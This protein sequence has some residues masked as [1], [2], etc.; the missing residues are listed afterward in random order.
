[1]SP[2]GQSAPTLSPAAGRPG[3]SLVDL[4]AIVGLVAVLAYL[5][6]RGRH[7]WYW[8]DEALS[9][10]MSSHP[11]AQLP[12][13]LAQDTSPPLYHVLLNLWVTWFGSSEAATHSLSTLFALAVVPA[14]LW[15][16]WSLF[17]RRTGWMCALLAAVSPFL[18]A[19]ANETR[20]YSLVALLS[21]LVTATFLHAFV[22][23]RRCFVPAFALLLA[24]TMYTHYWGF[25]LALGTGVALVVVVVGGVTGSA[26]RR[27][28]V[29][30]AVLAYGAAALLFAP[31]L[32]TL[33]YQRAHTVVGWAL[34]PTLQLVRDDVV[35]L[36]G[37]PVPAV[38]L[39]LGAG[40]ALVVLLRRP[41]DRRSLL[42]VAIVV[43]AVVAVAAGWATSRTNAQ[44]HGRYLGIVLAP[45]VLAFGVALARAGQTAVAALAIVAVL[46]APIGVRVPLYA[47][48]DAKGWV[49]EVAPLLERGDLVFAPIGAIPLL[50]HYL[51]DG[52]RYTTTTGPVADP[53]A[54]DWRDAMERLRTGDPVSSLSPLVD[55]LPVGGH[56][57]MSCPPVEGSELAGLPPYIEL[58]IRRCLEGRDYLLAHPRLDVETSLRFPAAPDAP[59]D[60]QLLTKLPSA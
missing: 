14:A 36:V 5:W 26:D 53:L 43:V 46:T 23:R 57:L 8:T 13:V 4:G 58:E 3:L 47:K 19:Y 40:G 29:L 15:A 10:G 54:A 49:Q 28:L 34:P 2:P 11:L 22:Y 48:S 25:F 21:L 7:T 45:V 52:L 12:E 37:G 59:V 33:L 51:P 17:D 6:S 50:A 30:D 41:W 44:W 42:T 39:A 9:L 27:C 38:A 31:W 55:R 20:M 56:V 18:A 16:G 32:P 1:M 24:M 35:G 60:A